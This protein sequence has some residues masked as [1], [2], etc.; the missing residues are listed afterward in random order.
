MYC[1]GNLKQNPAW[2]EESWEMGGVKA[3]NLKQRNFR[4]HLTN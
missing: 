3:E 2:D 1:E 4:K